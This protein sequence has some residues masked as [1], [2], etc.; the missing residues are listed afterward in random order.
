MLALLLTIA[1]MF[2]AVGTLIYTDSNSFKYTDYQIRM[3]LREQNIL[4]Q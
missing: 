2:A 1:T 3:F 4:H